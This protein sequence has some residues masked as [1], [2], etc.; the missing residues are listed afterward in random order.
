MKVGAGICGAVGLLE[1]DEGTSGWLIIMA[2]EDLDC[3]NLSK[4]SK[5]RHQLIH[6]E[7]LRKV[8]HKEDAILH[9]FL[10]SLLLSQ[11]NNL[12]LIVSQ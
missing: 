6:T 7:T 10:E 11:Y 9:G 2:R 4:A 12:S 5:V 1:A 3:L 8:L